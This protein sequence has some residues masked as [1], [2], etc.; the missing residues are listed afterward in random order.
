MVDEVQCMACGC[1]VLAIQD[2]CPL[3]EAEQRRVAEQIEA[4]EA[5]SNLTANQIEQLMS[6]LHPAL[7]D[8]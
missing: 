8:F 2:L 6:Q 3:C 4:Q 5:E 1:L 7:G